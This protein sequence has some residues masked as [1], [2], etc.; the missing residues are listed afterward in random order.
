MRNGF[1]PEVP[2]AEFAGVGQRALAVSL[3]E[4][5]ELMRG[6]FPAAWSPLLRRLV[7]RDELLLVEVSAAEAA[8]TGLQAGG[9]VTSRLAVAQALDAEAGRAA[10]LWRWLLEHWA[11]WS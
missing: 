11:V 10:E 6:V 4:V 2:A 8:L 9:L 1:G 3:A 5:R 7:A